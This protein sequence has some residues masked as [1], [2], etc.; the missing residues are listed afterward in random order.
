MPDRAQP[1][2]NKKRTCI[3]KKHPSEIRRDIDEKLSFEPD[4]LN[5]NRKPLNAA[6]VMD[7]EWEL[8]CGLSNQFRVLYKIYPDEHIV[9]IIAIGE[10]R[11]NRLFIDGVEY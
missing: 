10:K 8:R 4:V 3:I 9:N 6:V 1:E 7:S 2:C 5:R 11:G